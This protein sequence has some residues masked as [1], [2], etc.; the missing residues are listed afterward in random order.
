MDPQYLLKDELEYEL[1]CRGV[2]M[3]STVPVLKKL[4]KELMLAEQSEGRARDVKTPARKAEDIKSELDICATKLSVLSNYIA[5]IVGKPDKALFRRLV[6]RLY[7]VQNRVTLVI[8]V[9]EDDGISKDA[10]Q[11]KCQILLEKLEGLDDEVED[12]NLT[13]KDK[14]ILQQTLGD[15]GVR[16][17]DKLASA[18]HPSSKESEETPLGTKLGNQG[19]TVVNE[20]PDKSVNFAAGQWEGQTPGSRLKLLRSSTLEEES[21]KRKLVPIYQWGL[22][23]TG[24]NMSINAFLERVSE[25]RDARNATDFDLWRYAIDFFE[26][27]ALIWYRANREYASNWED[28]VILLKRSFQKPFYQEELL[29]EIRA[30]TQGRD[31]TVLIYV[32]I[33]QNMFNRL[34]SKLAETEKICILLRNIQ[35]YYQRAV[36]RDEFNSVSDLINVLRIVERTKINCDRFEEPKAVRNPLEPDLAHKTNNNSGEFREAMVMEE[37]AQLQGKPTVISKRCWN[38]REGGH[39]FRDCKMPKQRLFCYRCGR[40]GTTAK[41]CSCKGNALGESSNQ[42]P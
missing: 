8:P 39:L 24:S 36:C 12:D 37:V 11:Q 30:R 28:L 7:H 2:R 5:E 38:C 41:D 42:A 33:M 19:L 13:V 27:D 17:A 40:F 29:A 6:S 31:E 16:I 34:P 10:L 20:L 26:A 14:E 22:K 9:A 25:L 1:E 18:T 32:S 3:Q 23:F 15:L 21:P 4:L 35:P